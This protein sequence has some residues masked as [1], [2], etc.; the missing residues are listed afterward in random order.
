MYHLRLVFHET[1]MT[2]EVETQIS[3]LP[4]TLK[5]LETLWLFMVADIWWNEKLKYLNFRKYFNKFLFMDKCLSTGSWEDRYH[6]HWIS[7]Q[8]DQQRKTCLSMF[9]WSI[10]WHAFE[11]LNGL[12]YKY[13]LVIKKKIVTNLKLQLDSLYFYP[14]TTC[15]NHIIVILGSFFLLMINFLFIC[16]WNYTSFLRMRFLYPPKNWVYSNSGL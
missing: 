1:R 2:K 11:Y 3:N 8:R 7:W 13:S 5:D 10:L 4:V 15:R 9:F 6:S 14:C 12:N 16:F